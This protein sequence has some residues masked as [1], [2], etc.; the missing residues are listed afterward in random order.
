MGY[1][2]DNFLLNEVYEFKYVYNFEFLIIV[3]LVFCFVGFF[4]LVIVFI[5]GLLIDGGGLVFMICLFLII[6]FLFFVLLY[7][8]LLF[9]VFGSILL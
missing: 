8:F 9:D 3:L 5:I 6:F 2:L 4:E 7:M 1:L